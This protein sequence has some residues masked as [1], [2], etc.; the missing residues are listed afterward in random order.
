MS[1]HLH[2]SAPSVCRESKIQP[3]PKTMNALESLEDTDLSAINGGFDPLN[4][5]I[6]PQLPTGD[7]ASICRMLS[8][9]ARK[10]GLA[11]LPVSS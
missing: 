5:P 6:L 2:L 9:Q 10:N 3:Q 7:L 11:N 1:S 8:E 4:G